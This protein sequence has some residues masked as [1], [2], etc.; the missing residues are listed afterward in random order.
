MEKTCG[1]CESWRTVGIERGYCILDNLLEDGCVKLH[2][3]DDA[4][5]NKHTDIP[6]TLEQR[7]QQLAEITV[8]MLGHV[9]GSREFQVRKDGKKLKESRMTYQEYFGNKLRD[10]GI[11][12]DV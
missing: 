4:A 6:L 8:S 10:L 1:N 7:Y 9:E 3:R 5:C 11:G 2:L 12:I